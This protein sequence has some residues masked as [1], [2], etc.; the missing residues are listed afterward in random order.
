VPDPGDKSFRN[1]STLRFQTPAGRR[2]LAA[3]HAPTYGIR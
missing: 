1:V 2:L 3:Q